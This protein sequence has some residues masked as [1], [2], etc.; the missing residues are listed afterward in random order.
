VKL[1]DLVNNKANLLIKEVYEEIPEG[2]GDIA[3]S[4][5]IIGE[6]EEDGIV[7]AFEKNL[8]WLWALIGFL[9]IVGVVIWLKAKGKSKPKK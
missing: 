4:G 1:I 7:Q 5:E 6:D 2:E 3:T 8:I 9:L